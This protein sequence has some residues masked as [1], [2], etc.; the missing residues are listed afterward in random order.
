MT[1]RN[2]DTGFERAGMARIGGNKGARSM[3]TQR[4]KSWIIA[5][6]VSLVLCVVALCCL[7][8]FSSDSKAEAKQQVPASLAGL[9]LN[10]TAEYK[11]AAGG[12]VSL[13]KNSYEAGDDAI[14]TWKGGVSGDCFVIPTTV[15]FNGMTLH[16]DTLNRVD[17][18][19]TPNDEYLRRMN[20]D[21]TMTEFDTIK[22]YIEKGNSITIPYLTLDTNIEVQF[23]KVEPVYRLYNMI[24]SEH[25][26]TS[27][28]DEYD[29]WVSI[30]LN[31]NDYWIG[32]GID[33]LA[34]T[35]DTNSQETIRLYNP[36]LGADQKSSHYYTT[37]TTEVANLCANWG[38]TKEGTSYRYKSGKYLS[39]S[40]KTAVYTCYNEDLKSAHHY[41]SS[42]EEWRSLAKSNWDLE[43]WKNK[44]DGVFQCMMS[45]RWY[46]PSSYYTIEHMQQGADGKYTLF[47]AQVA[48]GEP[49]DTTNAKAIEYPGFT[50]KTITQKTITSDNQTVVK[51]QYTR[52]AYAVHFDGNGFDIDTPDQENVLY[53]DSI[54]DPGTPKAPAGYEFDGWYWDRKTTKP[55][56]FDT[57]KMPA[58]DLT[59]YAKWKPKSGISYKILHMKEGLDGEYHADDTELTETEYK[60]GTTGEYTA[61]VAKTYTG[62]TSPR[63]E[64]A[65][66][67]IEGDGSTV[68]ELKY[69][70]N[71]YNVIFR[72]NGK[73]TDPARTTC[74]YGDKIKAPENPHVQGWTISGWYTDSEVFTSDTLWKFDE[75]TMGEGS[76]TLYAKW[77]VNSY[78]VYFYPNGGT[79][80]ND[81]QIRSF[82]DG[83]NL[84]RNSFTRAGYVFTGWN[85][86]ADG[87]G[88]AVE[89][90]TN[91]TLVDDN[92]P[93][94]SLYAQWSANSYTVHFDANTGVGSMDSV[95]RVFDDGKKLPANTFTKRGYLF[96]GWNT[97][98]DGSGRSYDDEST[99]NV[100]LDNE[101]DVTLYVKWKP[102]EFK[103]IYHKN[104]EKASESEIIEKEQVVT[105]NKPYTLDLN[106]FK[107][108]GYE[109]IGWAEDPD[110]EA[111][112]MDG[113]KLGN[114]SSTQGDEIHFYAKWKMTEPFWIAP[115][116]TITTGNTA[117]TANQSNPNYKD[118]ESE[119][120]KSSAQI[121]DEVK[122][123]KNKNGNWQTLKAEYEG[124]MNND[125]YHL[126]TK[127]GEGTDV[128]DYAEF[129]IIN[130]GDHNIATGDSTD[131]SVLTFQ[132]VHALPTGYMMNSDGSNASSWSKTELYSNLNSGEIFSGFNS[133]F[134]GKIMSVTKKTSDGSKKT[135]INSTYDNKLWL[136]SLVEM[137]GDVKS[138][139]YTG[140]LTFNK[141]G[142]QYTY[143]KNLGLSSATGYANPALS[144]LYKTRSGKV[145]TNADTNRTWLRS[146]QVSDTQGYM[147]IEA[148][149]NFGNKN[150]ANRYAS[151][152]PCFTLG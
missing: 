64:P 2:S 3:K 115:A 140:Y 12:S 49:G 80:A 68:V 67:L 43:T 25:L 55:F 8:T 30:G 10:V 23:V 98:A 128:D 21:V 93:S 139:N 143:Y 135:T 85:T 152:A 6:F 14:L 51:V 60:T 18:L 133:D 54:L 138:G 29:E 108:N 94:I 9:E 129:R 52:D 149:G 1:G 61:A 56:D 15:T 72:S 41:T 88:I 27:N 39:D 28:K 118:P 24:T 71:S 136:P 78:T 110:G 86:K 104:A 97:A 81:Y 106:T 53:G 91:K 114:L 131:G 20:Q 63:V 22:D 109:F 145:P 112:Y 84:K 73:G 79:G 148:A 4:S 102:I 59:I 116:S 7:G 113:A 137:V 105:Y 47:E 13:D 65:Q 44:D 35:T 87:T 42:K 132:A 150:N 99:D 119:I 101:T 134:T 92:E 11:G 36:N 126:Y 40:K 89:D 95:D 96:N 121:L 82:D 31:N 46:T 151:V 83:K 70:R 76:I 74:K 45:V 69:S 130:V 48:E 141:E 33:W 17:M 111:I 32:E 19:Q 100:I 26:F 142:T 34:P 37:D 77:T 5:C 147:I 38:W 50:A 16:I 127:L 62:F 120:T 103:I 107:K 75:D 123:M 58:G 90:G 66:K 124:Y 144:A 117:D 125:N 146:P 122:Q 57:A